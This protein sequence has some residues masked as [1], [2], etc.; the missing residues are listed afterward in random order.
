SI[1]HMAGYDHEYDTTNAE[2]MFQKQ[3]MYLKNL[4]A[5]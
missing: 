1:L 5:E 3:E 4:F 2:E